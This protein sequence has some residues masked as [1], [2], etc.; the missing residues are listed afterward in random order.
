MKKLR[1]Q[2]HKHG[3]FVASLLLTSAI[4]LPLVSTATRPMSVQEYLLLDLSRNITTITGLRLAIFGLIIIN[5][6]L[7]YG[8]LSAWFAKRRAGL[9]TF[10]LACIPVWL[11]MQLAI[12]RFTLVL[13]PILLSLWAFDRAGRSHQRAAL[14]YALSGLATTAAWLQEPVGVTIVMILC[15]ILLVGIKPRYAKHIGRQASLVLIILIATVA[16]LAA[17]SWKFD[18]GIQDYLVRQLSAGV[19]ITLMPKIFLQ[20]PA[21]YHVGIPGVSLIPLSVAVLAGLGA[22][23]LFV[24]RKRPRNTYLL[25]LPVVFVAASIPFGGLTT[26]LLGSIAMV[27]VA[28]WTVMGIQYLHV[29]WKR[30]FPHNRLANTVGD[31]LIVTMLTSL[32]LY[33]FWYTNK[34]WN[35]NP[36]TRIDAATEWSGKL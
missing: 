4:L 23:Q 14:W 9:T 25:A 29:S 20:G 6:T 22:W 27:G 36:Q 3:V 26:L 16:A 21:S 32:A 13:T 15:S 1:R 33:S 19:Q 8:L 24:T 17:A 28:V 31:L 5:M 7:V 34:A 18:L 12:P 35:G 11:I 30:V 10:V 2:I